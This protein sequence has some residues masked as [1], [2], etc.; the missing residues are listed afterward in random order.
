[1]DDT[2]LKSVFT[3]F[4]KA[5]GFEVLASWSKRWNNNAKR[6]QKRQTKAQTV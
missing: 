1:M 4:R 6:Q 3:S 2:M 5:L